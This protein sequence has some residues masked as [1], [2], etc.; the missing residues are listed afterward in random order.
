MRSYH[1]HPARPGDLFTT[2]DNNQR[3]RLKGRGWT[4][5]SRRDLDTTYGRPAGDSLAK[6]LVGRYHWSEMSRSF[7]RSTYQTETA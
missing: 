6:A 4:K 1:T 3:R 5:L 7:V 2:G